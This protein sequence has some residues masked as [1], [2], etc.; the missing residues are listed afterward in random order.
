MKHFSDWNAIFTNNPSGHLT[1]P[2]KIYMNKFYGLCH[3]EFDGQIHYYW[4][5]KV[6]VDALPVC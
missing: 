6:C 4:Y 1:T 5:I 3:C 2:K